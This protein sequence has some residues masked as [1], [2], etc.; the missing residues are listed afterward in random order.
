MLKNKFKNNEELSIISD[1]Y[2]LK[3][4]NSTIKNILQSTKIIEID[5]ILNYMK[6]EAEMYNIDFNILIH[7]SV[8]YMI[9]NYISIDKLGTLLS[10]HIKNAIIAINSKESNYKSILIT[11]GEVN[12]NYGIVIH[13]TGI[14]FKINT[15]INLG[16]KAITTHKSGTGFGFMT[17]FETLKETKASLEISEFKSDTYTKSISIIFDNKCEYR[18]KTYRENEI[19]NNNSNNKITFI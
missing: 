17:T 7:G 8:H 11:I 9:D 16:L 14:N 2:K 1:D 4:K 10:D 18:I 15:L 13:D 19:K 3:I 5:D 12:D 6:E